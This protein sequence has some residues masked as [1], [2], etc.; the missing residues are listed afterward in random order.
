MTETKS[1]TIK[2][3]TKKEAPLKSTSANSGF[4]VL[5][6]GGKQYKVKAGD[7]IK[8]EKLPKAEEGKKVI[9]DKVLLEDDGKTTTLGTPY[10]AK[11]KIEAEVTKIGRAKKVTVVKYK[12]KARY[13][14]KRGH[15]QLFVELKISKI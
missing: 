2:K 15:R 14:K 10:I 9:F 3:T 12:A 13:H 1:K 4:S 8:V 5:E 11:A 6:T 7:I